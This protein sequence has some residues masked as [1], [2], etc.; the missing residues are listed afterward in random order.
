M[1]LL[2]AILGG[3]LA[4]TVEVRTDLAQ[5]LPPGRTPASAFL[6]RELQTGAAN[7]LLLAGIE[8]AAPEELAR[9]SRETAAALR[10][11]E[12]FE[13]VGDGTIA[14]SEA[15]QE[16]LFR[17]RYLL[18]PDVQAEDFTAAS[19][20]PRL[21]ALLE[22]L[23][24]A[25]S[26]LLVRF[27]FADPTGAFLDLARNWLAGAPVDTRHGAWFAAGD[28][29]PRALLVARMRGE[30]GLDAEAQRDAVAAFHAG[31]A[32]ARPGP[33]RLLL[34]GPGVFAA[35]AAAVIRA[36]VQRV[37]LASIALLGA[38]LFW[39]YRSIP[40]LALVAVPLA[41]G[42]IA[43]LAATAAFTG[44]TVHGITLGFGMTMLGVTIDYPIL[45]V[46][47]R[48]PGETMAAAAARIWPTLRLAAASA[49]A[50][51]AAMLG[52]GFPGLVQLG[53]FAGTGLLAAAAT[54]RWVLPMLMPRTLIE[55]RPLPAPLRAV[56]AALDGRRR[57][58][59]V[60]VLVAA[61]GLAAAG[62][63]AW[64]R[65]LAALSPVPQ[66][67]QALDAELRR[68]LGAPDVRFL[69]ALGPGSE[70]EVLEASERLGRT[71]AP[72]IGP[73]G[74][75]AGL[76]LPSGYL[77][78][79]A[80]QQARR[81]ALPGPGPLREELRLAQDGL[82][83][84]PTAFAPFLAAVEES[85]SLPP[86]N[87][88]VLAADAPTIAARLSP[89][90]SRR[91]DMVQGVALA[92]GVTDP[93]MLA[94]AAG[95]LGDPRILFVDVKAE[96][97]GMLATY[98]RATL[99][100]ALAGGVLVLGMLALSLRSIPRVL[101]VAT[102]IGGALVVTLAVLT[103][104]GEAL[105]LFHLASLLLLAGLAIDYSLFFAR[106]GPDPDAAEDDTL[107]AVLNCT[108]STLLTF[109]LLAF[110][111]TP[112]LHGIGLTV[113]VGVASAFL[114]ANAMAPRA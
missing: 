2:L 18:S 12:R 57:L 4:A 44:G 64:Q 63:P 62:G 3:T 78:S 34:S 13:F 8:G 27:S 79:P 5:V 11:S 59:A 16:F 101:Q 25:A 60:V 48:R 90:L 84:R 30:G 46:T 82:P 85:R 109:G 80:T 104:L 17:Y 55:P 69:F 47:L 94:A 54:T 24:S 10:A 20:R 76:D 74:A 26:L 6:V 21:E 103:A 97:E 107:G 111:A 68:Q 108:V 37:A 66:A 52:S 23:R 32:A 61:A 98:A 49:A 105:T 38:F 65:D 7:T 19:L 86:L 89:L 87:A 73:D 106:T 71:L 41:A 53:I 112:V 100:W 15:E 99:S 14:P 22:G 113:S 93:T 81:Q 51:L 83:F 50:G 39:R 42:T 75:L 35:E 36:D 91:E 33:A 56:L 72:L 31:F 114:L 102:P 1:L 110:S 58:A 29:P 95:R 40:L 92:R 45:L 28:G 43:G 9:L 70:A 96:T 67:A 77:P 88:G